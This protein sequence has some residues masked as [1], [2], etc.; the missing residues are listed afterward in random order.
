MTERK[1]TP[2]RIFDERLTALRAARGAR[3]RAA[4]GKSGD[5][6]LLTRMIDD[7]AGRI[8]DVTRAFDRVMLIAPHGTADALVHRLPREKRPAHLH[9]AYPDEH[10]SLAIDPGTFDLALALLGPGQVNDLPGALIEMRTLLKPDGLLIAAWP[11][12]D[13]L[14]E[15]RR[16]LYADDQARRGGLTPRVHPMVD[17]RAAAQLLARA[18]LAM[19]VVDT[20]RFTVRYQSLGTLFSDLRDLGLTN[21]LADRDKTYLGRDALAR[22]SAH[23]PQEDGRYPATFDILWLTAWSPHESQPKPLKPGTAQTRLAD[24][25]GVKERKL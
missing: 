1:P 14:T 19:P 6:F 23:Y 20:D 18:G 12:G 4:C 5:S 13:S 2:P 7:L 9:I 21:A 24:A 17:H 10:L 22:I 25:L 8:A 16:A 15:L 3:R 11:G